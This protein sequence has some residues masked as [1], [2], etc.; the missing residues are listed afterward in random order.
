MKKI[1]DALKTYFKEQGITQKQIAEELDVSP[2]YVNSL[3]KGDKEFGK[4]QANFFGKKFGISPYW[5]L[6]GEGEM[7]ISQY[8]AKQNATAHSLNSLYGDSDRQ[9]QNDCS[10][11]TKPHPDH[12]DLSHIKNEQ[13][14][15]L[16]EQIRMM[17][18]QIRMREEQIR[19]R[20][21]QI[22]LKDEQINK[23]LEIIANTTKK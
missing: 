4:K 2:S 10:E 1:G 12:Q 6:S 18:E 11:S 22:R 16:Y 14:R 20:D 9:N 19:M 3:L 23:L 5:L 8:I 21:E 15:L 7:L 17:E 13:V